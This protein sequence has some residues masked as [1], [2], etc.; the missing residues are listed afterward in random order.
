MIKKEILFKETCLRLTFQAAYESI[1]DLR[2]V[3]LIQASRLEQEIAQLRMSSEGRQLVGYTEEVLVNPKNVNDY[4]SIS[5]EY[6]YADKPKPPKKGAVKK[7][8]EKFYARKAQITKMHEK[9][10]KAAKSK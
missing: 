6:K 5:L 8:R 2:D 9:A 7:L 10:K 4:Y 1:G 3:F